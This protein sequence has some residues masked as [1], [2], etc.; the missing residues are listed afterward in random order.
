LCTVGNHTHTHVRPE[1]LGADELDECSDQIES[2]LGLR[3]AHFAY[4]WGLPVPAAEPLI[5]DRF[6]SAVLGTLGVNTPGQD[7][8][9]LLRIPVRRTD[10]LPFFRAKLDGALTAERAYSAVVGGAKKVGARA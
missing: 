8:H 6:R 5:R 7:V 9:R 4:T 1:R 3:P 10:P 2:H